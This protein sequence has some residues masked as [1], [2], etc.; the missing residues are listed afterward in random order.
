MDDDEVVFAVNE[1]PIKRHTLGEISDAVAKMALE[2][3]NAAQH[4]I[5]LTAFGVG[6]AVLILNDVVLLVV[7]ITII[8]GR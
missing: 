5:H 8:G 2:K 7:A 4:R 6:L 3:V 1:S